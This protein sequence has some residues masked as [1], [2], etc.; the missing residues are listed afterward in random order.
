MQL[1][2]SNNLDKGAI[3]TVQE[4]TTLKSSLLLKFK[5]FLSYTEDPIYAEQPVNTGVLIHFAMGESG[6]KL[7]L[8]GDKYFTHICKVSEHCLAAQR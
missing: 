6:W 2:V 1:G 5:N 4:C 7:Y 3:I 8:C